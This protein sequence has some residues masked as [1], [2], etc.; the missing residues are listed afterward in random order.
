MKVRELQEKLSNL[1]P[2]LP[3]VFYSEDEML[4]AKDCGFTLF[5]VTNVSERQ[6]ERTRLDSDL[7]PVMP[8]LRS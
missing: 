5:D 3:V 4:L 6:A 2:E 1:D 7:L 8:S